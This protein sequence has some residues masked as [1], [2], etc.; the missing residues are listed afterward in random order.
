[1]TFANGNN[2]PDWLPIIPLKGIPS[3]SCAD[4]T[5]LTSQKLRIHQRKRVSERARTS[6]WLTLRC[7]SA[8]GPLLPGWRP[9]SVPRVQSEPFNG[10]THLSLRQAVYLVVG[11]VPKSRSWRSLQVYQ[12]GRESDQVS[13]STA[14]PVGF[15]H[16]QPPGNASSV[17]Q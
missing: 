10:H 1:M 9:V 17:T 11:F 14:D 6:S 8:E 5:M 2:R 7:P 4:L 12:V 3:A 13:L 15:Y 16:D